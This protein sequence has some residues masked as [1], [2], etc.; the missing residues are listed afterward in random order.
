MTG[1]WDLVVVGAGPAGSAT[2]LGALHRDPRLRVLLLDRADFPRDK[3]CG[4][5]IAPHVLDVLTGVGVHGLLDD[6]VPL[7]RL[8][9]SIA[10]H[11]AD[12][13]LARP[14]WVVPRT[15]LDARLVARAEAAGAVRERRRVRSLDELDARVVV[16]A[17]GAHSVVRRDLLGSAPGHRALAIRGAKSRLSWEKQIQ[18]HRDMNSNP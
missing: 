15:E 1:R 4:D 6:Q 10:G 7:R 8:T 9:I 11:V 5:G 18:T 14:V 16:G 3:A 13:P 17:D 12:G 2:A